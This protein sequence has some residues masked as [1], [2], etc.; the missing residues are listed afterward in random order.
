MNIKNT[1]QVDL[2]HHTDI[3]KSSISKYL[4]C[5]MK[6]ERTDYPKLQKIEIW[7]NHVGI[8]K[9]DVPRKELISSAKLYNRRDTT[10]YCRNPTANQG[11]N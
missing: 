5:E 7:L 8:G 2:C 11:L 9:S 1:N 6:H 3:P 10:Q 4:P